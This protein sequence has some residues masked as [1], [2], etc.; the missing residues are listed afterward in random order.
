[1]V[2]RM[3]NGAKI[4]VTTIADIRH[5]L[6]QVDFLQSESFTR[7]LEIGRGLGF[8]GFGAKVPGWAKLTREESRQCIANDFVFNGHSYLV[9]V[10]ELDL[11]FTQ[12]GD[13]G[14]VALARALALT[15]LDLSGT[16]VGDAGVVAL[17]RAPALTTLIL[18]G[19]QVGD[20]G[21]VALARAPVLTTLDLSG[22][23]V[24][25]AGVAALARAPALTTLILRDTRVTQQT[26]LDVRR[27]YP[28]LS[29]DY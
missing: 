28:R 10:T 13:A 6:E 18:W 3:P 12:V 9:A 5:V 24:R 17:A 19:T 4:R 25:D 20:E 29:I 27:R 2:A 26:I 23:Q 22:T 1:M 15:T 14:V 8:V 16:Q 21:V 7:I 11:A